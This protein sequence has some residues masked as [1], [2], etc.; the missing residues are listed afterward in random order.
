MLDAA[1]ESRAFPESSS[2]HR[3]PSRAARCRRAHCPNEPVVDIR[4]A[5]GHDSRWW[6]YCAEHLAAY[7]LEVREGVVWWRG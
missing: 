3:V 2:D 7:N 6:A 5:H 1:T 4:R